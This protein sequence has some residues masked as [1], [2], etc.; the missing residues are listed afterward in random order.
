MIG[1]LHGCAP[2]PD[3]PTT[4][5]TLSGSRAVKPTRGSV[6]KAAKR[7]FECFL[8][9][10]TLSVS[11]KVSMALPVLAYS[12]VERIVVICRVDPED[13]GALNKAEIGRLARQVIIDGL[14]QAHWPVVVASP[15]D[16]AVADPTALV[17]V[18]HANAAADPV[19]PGR[20]A[21]AVAV[22]R[23]GQVSDAVPLFLAPPVAVALRATESDMQRALRTLLLPAV[24][25]PMMSMPGVRQTND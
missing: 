17:V 18:I 23:P 6:G 10:L 7:I 12:P 9:I 19:Q 15:G 8:L 20:A 3:V 11:W 16:A 14:A 21:I 22:R 13:T 25:E 5:S 24:I 4:A 2:L 1:F